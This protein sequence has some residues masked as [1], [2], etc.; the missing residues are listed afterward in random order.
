MGLCEKDK[1]HDKV[2]KDIDG[3]VAALDANPDIAS[4]LTSP[5]LEP[6]SK[7]KVIE[8]IAKSLGCSQISTNF[9]LYLSDRKRF[10]ELSGIA[11]DFRVLLDETAGRIQADVVTATPLGPAD[12]IRI[13]KALEQ[14]S[15]KKV[16][17]SATVDPEL[18]GGVVTIVGNIVLDG[19]V[20][21]ALNR[22]K[23]QLLAAVQ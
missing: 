4:A 18:V 12:K 14:A 7:R 3:V 21:T 8:S 9:L 20:R 6:T 1:S 22:M 13:Q 23:T 10:D 11:T 15:G 17:L 19:S 16:V 5:S 2:A